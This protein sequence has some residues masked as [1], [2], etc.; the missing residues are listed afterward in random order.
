MGGFG[1]KE[2]QAILSLVPI[3]DDN[4]EIIIFAGKK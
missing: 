2:P 1:G 3:M 4:K